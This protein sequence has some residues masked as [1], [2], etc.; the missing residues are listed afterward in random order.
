VNACMKNKYSAT[1]TTAA[2]IYFHIAS[3]PND[4]S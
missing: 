1:T 4:K 3:A 2:V